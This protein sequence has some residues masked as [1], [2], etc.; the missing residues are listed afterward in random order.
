MARQLPEPQPLQGE[1]M[2]DKGNMSARNARETSAATPKSAAPDPIY[3][4]QFTAKTVEDVLRWIEARPHH[5]A[6]WIS[7]PGFFVLGGHGYRLRVPELLQEQTCRLLRSDGSR[8]DNR[9][10]RANAAGLARLRRA[11]K[12]ALAAAR[13]HSSPRQ[14][15]Q[16]IRDTQ[17]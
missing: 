1:D 8:F 14:V 15:E 17:S 11:A 4:S 6:S 10:Y 7:D 3:R 13:E 5:F 2:K 9:M 12:K 16:P